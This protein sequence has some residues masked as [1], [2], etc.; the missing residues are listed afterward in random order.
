[1]APLIGVHDVSVLLV[2]QR[3]HAYAYAVGSL[4]HSPVVALTTLPTFK[5]PESCGRTVLSGRG[6]TR[7]P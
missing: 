3:C 1:M 7:T 6:G 2:A 5:V 4:P